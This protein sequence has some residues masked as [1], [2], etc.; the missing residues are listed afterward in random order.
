MK[1]MV[2]LKDARCRK[3]MWYEIRKGVWSEG[4]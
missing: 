4:N 3:S 1:N 2:K